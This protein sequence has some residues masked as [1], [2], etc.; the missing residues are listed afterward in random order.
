MNEKNRHESLTQNAGRSGQ[1]PT[2][3]LIQ[4]VSLLRRRRTRI[5]LLEDEPCLREIVGA[6]FQLY[7]RD[8]ILVFSG[9]GDE[10]WR[11][12]S[13]CAPDL[14]ITDY[15]HCGMRIEEMLHRLY[16]R[17]DKFPILVASSCIGDRDLRERLL[18]FPG[19]T[20]ELLDKPF[21]VTDLKA[22]VQKCLG[23][24]PPYPSRQA[25]TS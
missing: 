3:A 14:L 20:I 7:F 21:Q 17:P 6:V 1:R 22:K 15:N 24:G 13:R 12:I 4:P 9:D 16:R 11:E 23:P 19:F 2:P 8:Y 18:G 5:F 10:A 25:A